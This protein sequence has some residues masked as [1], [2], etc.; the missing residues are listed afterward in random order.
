MR[1]RT[2]G[3]LIWKGTIKCIYYTRLYKHKSAF[4]FFYR[5][6]PDDKRSNAQYYVKQER[7]RGGEREG[8]E[9]TKPQPLTLVT[10]T[11][12][13]TR[14]VTPQRTQ[15]VKPAVFLLQNKDK[16]PFSDHD[17]FILLPLSLRGVFRWSQDLRETS[18]V[19][20]NHYSP[21]PVCQTSIRQSELNQQSY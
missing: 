10:T 1:P 4:F 6:V 7:E 13:K 20:W 15:K 18:S 16:N 14:K 19:Q 17:F 3:D 8:S 21:H 2:A 11:G 9:P 12:E 5:S